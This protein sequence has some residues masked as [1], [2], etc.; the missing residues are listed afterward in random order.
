M[1]LSERQLERTP[2]APATLAR[3]ARLLLAAGRPADAVEPLERLVAIEPENAWAGLNLAR[4]LHKAG[5]QAES[6]DAIC[7][8]L[9]RYPDDAQARAFQARL[10]WRS[11]QPAAAADAARAALAAAPD[12]LKLMRD[13]QPVL[14]AQARA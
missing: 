12:D 11:G 10:L 3:H 7:R 14:A 2:D 5:R 13:L 8:L 4:T 1:R 9:D 6:L